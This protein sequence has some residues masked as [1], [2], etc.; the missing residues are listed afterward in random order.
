MI[1]SAHSAVGAEWFLFLG[2]VLY[3]VWERLPDVCNVCP[4]P[5]PPPPPSFAL[6]HSRFPVPVFPSFFPFFFCCGGDGGG[7]RKQD[8]THIYLVRVLGWKYCT[9]HK[10]PDTF[11]YSIMY[12]THVSKCSLYVFTIIPPRLTDQC[13]FITVL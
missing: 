12:Q 7:G 10:G 5:S 11:I 1:A 3:T 4:P 8:Q 13:N 6:P 9:R 2:V